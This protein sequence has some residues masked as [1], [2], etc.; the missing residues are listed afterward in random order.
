M[1]LTQGEMIG[2]LRKKSGKTQ[3]T[4]GREMGGQGKDQCVNLMKRIEG[5]SRNISQAE[6]EKLA[7]IIGVDPRL[8][9][10]Y[11]LDGGTEGTLPR[12]VGDYFDGIWKRLS[13][14]Q[15][16]IEQIEDIPHYEHVLGLDVVG[17]FTKFYGTDKMDTLLKEIK[18][19]EPG[20]T[21]TTTTK[22]RKRA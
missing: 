7:D 20:I 18:A 3:E 17:F 16:L 4:V 22:K 12:N 6:R 13:V 5:D 21:T 11:D 19:N 8:L 2:L 10:Q 9:T 14:W 15:M 1:V